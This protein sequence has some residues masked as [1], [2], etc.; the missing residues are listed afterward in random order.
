M[1][2]F[3]RE[4]H[5]FITPGIVELIRCY[6]RTF[7]SDVDTVTE[8]LEEYSYTEE[9]QSDNEKWRTFCFYV[10]LLQAGRIRGIREERARRK[11]KRKT[12][13]KI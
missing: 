4:H 7:I 8:L 3:N 5:N 9:A 2:E 13:K 11:A 1:K 10:T 6:N 12:D